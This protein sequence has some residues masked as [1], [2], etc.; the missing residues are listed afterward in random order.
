MGVYLNWMG[1][2]G[3]LGEQDG[4]AVVVSTRAPLAPLAVQ[5]GKAVWQGKSGGA[6]VDIPTTSTK[7]AWWQQR[8]HRVD[9]AVAGNGGGR[10]AR[11]EMEK[12]VRRMHN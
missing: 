1:L 11:Q 3:L 8:W 5:W 12:T 2:E 4:P 10:G 6:I 9:R 7:L